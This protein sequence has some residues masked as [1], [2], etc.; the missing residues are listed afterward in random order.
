M[1]TIK[2]QTGNKLLPKAKKKE[3]EINSEGLTHTILIL[4]RQELP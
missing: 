1:L 2:T 4:K 3:K